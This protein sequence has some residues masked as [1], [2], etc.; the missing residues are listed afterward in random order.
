MKVVVALLVLLM[1]ASAIAEGTPIHE[2]QEA[3][4]PGEER[5]KSV[6]FEGGFVEASSRLWGTSL[7]PIEIIPM[8]VTREKGRRIKKGINEITREAFRPR[9]KA[10]T[11][12]PIKKGI[13]E[14]TR[15]AIDEAIRESAR[16]AVGDRE[17][18]RRKKDPYWWLED[19]YLWL[20]SPKVI[21]AC[22]ALFIILCILERIGIIGILERKIDILERK[23]KKNKKAD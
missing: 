5:G 9:F 17:E 15:E 10:S 12:E 11:E 20:T 21:I 3:Q 2:D 7:G 16:R 6:S 1:G 4:N 8:E 13:N 19:F 23:Q 14:I 22:I 18:R